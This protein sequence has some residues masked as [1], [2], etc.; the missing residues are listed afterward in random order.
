MEGRRDG[1]QAR[2]VSPQTLLWYR[3]SWYLI[4]FC[5]S[6]EA[7]HIFALSRMDQ[8]QLLGKVRTSL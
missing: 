8:P 4:A 5:H 7:L 3:D 1:G 6:R 2:S